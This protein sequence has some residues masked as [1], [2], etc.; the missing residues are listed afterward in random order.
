MEQRYA[1]WCC[2]SCGDEN[3]GKDEE[4][5]KCFSEQPPNVEFYELSKIT[6]QPGEL[7][8]DIQEQPHWNC[9]SCGVMNDFENVRCRKCLQ[10]RTE[11][12]I[13]VYN[14]SDEKKQEKTYNNL[15]DSLGAGEN[16]SESSNTNIVTSKFKPIH[17]IGAVVLLLLVVLG[18]MFLF[19]FDSKEAGNKWEVTVEQYETR[20]EK[21]TTYS[22]VNKSNYD[23]LYSEIQKTGY[24]DSLVGYKN[25]TKYNTEVV[26]D[27]YRIVSKTKQVYLGQDC[28]KV[29]KTV[30]TTVK[31][32]PDTKKKDCRNV[33]ESYTDKVPRKVNNGN[34]RIT[35]K[36][37]NVTK[38]RTIKKCS[39]IVIPG[40]TKQVP[41]TVYE[42]KCED[43]YKTVNY[44][45]KEPKYKT[46]QI[47]YIDK[48]PQYIAVPVYKRAYSY[49]VSS[50]VKVN[51]N[52]IVV[53][54]QE[55]LDILLS[56]Y[57]RDR[58]KQLKVKKLTKVVSTNIFGYTNVYYR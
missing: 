17:Y 2:P 40:K 1:F 37:D 16:V 21:E 3:S 30:Y 52:S 36:Y 50:R 43:K 57:N 10:D 26:P 38:Y 5:K 8:E 19:T 44:T 14:E 42:K 20:S 12:D 18:L 25:V 6:G 55:E 54:S 49:K 51:E 45:E 34:G 13:A 24:T 28:K 39:D 53:M 4:C 9:V 29:P 27:G 33:Q 11:Y 35:T 47:P 32:T 58:N 31:V 56:K 23:L 7:C 46:V 22:P 41:K 48:V 15:Y